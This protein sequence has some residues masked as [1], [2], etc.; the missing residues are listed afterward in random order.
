MMARLKELSNTL[1]KLDEDEILL[2]KTWF[3]RILMARMPEEE[4][5]NVEKIFLSGHPLTLFQRQ[6]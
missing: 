4:R 6:L 1:K 3:K 5:K 2:F